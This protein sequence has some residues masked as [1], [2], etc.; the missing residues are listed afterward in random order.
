[1]LRSVRQPRLGYRGYRSLQA[2]KNLAIYRWYARRK[3][4]PDYPT[5]ADDAMGAAGHD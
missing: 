1:M 3:Y 2:V 5:S 4:G